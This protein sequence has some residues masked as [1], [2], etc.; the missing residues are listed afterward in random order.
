MLDCR[1]VIEDFCL[2]GRTEK[3][4]LLVAMEPIRILKLMQKLHASQRIGL[5]SDLCL[6]V[7]DALKHFVYLFVDHQFMLVKFV[8]FAIRGCR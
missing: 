3:N 4:R 2:A 5:G 8:H 7:F 1:R 6:D